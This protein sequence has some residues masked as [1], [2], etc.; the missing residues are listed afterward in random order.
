MH[1]V[2]DAHLA[3]KKIDGVARYLIGLLSKLP[4]LDRSIRYTILELPK[5]QSGLP[6]KIFQDENVDRVELDLPG[7]SPRQHLFMSK[8]LN[9]LN[10]NVYH[11]PQYDLPIG[12]K[13]ATVATIHDLKFLFYPQFL[14]RHSKLKSW[15]IK[16]SLKHTVKKATQIIA[17]SQNTLSDLKQISPTVESRTKVIYHGVNQ[18]SSGLQR[19]QNLPVD[20][21][22]DFILFVGTR[23]PHKNIEGLINAF[24][25]LR[26]QHNLEVDLVIAGKA[27][28]EHSLPEKT[29]KATGMERHTHFLDFVSDSELEALYSRAKVVA[30]PSFYEG[31]GFPLVEAMAHGKPVVASNITSIPE[32]VGE[33]GLLFDPNEPQ[34]IAAKILR[35]LTEPLLYNKLSQA[36][37]KRAS[38]FEWDKV[39]EATLEVYLAAASRVA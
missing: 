34:D 39:A 16:Q 38:A 3:V 12:L 22:G 17:V 4:R 32:V 18:R 23:R 9:Q 6:Q 19:N 35:V 7:P 31:F 13:L 24:S 29:A 15:Y 30:L 11:H 2:I 10:A 37:A 14:T 21:S 27:Y 36:A 5:S 1:I 26:T 20:I 28:S 8:I 25:I 33:A